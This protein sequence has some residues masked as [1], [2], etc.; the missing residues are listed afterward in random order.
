MTDHSLP[1]PCPR[2]VAL[3]AEVERLRAQVAVLRGQ[4]YSREDTEPAAAVRV[5]DGVRG[6]AMTGRRNARW[7][8]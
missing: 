1:P 3:A 8:A 5:P 4:D 7:A 6:L 2:C